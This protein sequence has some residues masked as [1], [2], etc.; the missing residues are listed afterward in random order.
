MGLFRK[1]FVLLSA[2]QF[3][4]AAITSC[5]ADGILFTGIGGTKYN[6]CP[7]TDYQG[8]SAQ[9]LKGVASVAA[10][11][12]L[13]DQ[14]PICQKAVYDQ[15]GAQCHIKNNTAGGVTWVT[16]D[17]YTTITYDNALPE[18]KNIATCP[19]TETA[20]TNNGNVY[21]TCINT[22]IRGTSS[23]KIN[24]VANTTA[25]AQLCATAQDGGCANAV[26]DKVG[27]VCHIKADATSNTLIWYT[28]KRYDVIR[29][30]VAADPATQG[31]WSDLIRLPVIPVAAY[32]VP[33]FPE[34]S[35]ML[36]WSSWGVDAFGGEG[37]MTQFADYNF[38]T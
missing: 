9:I 10:C 20:T 4:S 19:F 22:D 5:P 38:N 14:D 29:Q 25:C 1:S 16:S 6:V 26:Y 37:G 27:A 36:V 32:V 8:L 18:Q 23:Q 2:I 15:E 30:D 3:V 35:R 7:S 21:K 24:N 34:S 13:C 17:K 33:A 28:N 12:Q 31:S 11:A